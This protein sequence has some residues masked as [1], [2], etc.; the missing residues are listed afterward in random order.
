[1]PTSHSYHSYLI[2]SLGDPQEAAA[3]LDAVLED[4]TLEELRLAT[5]NVAEAR[6][7]ILDDVQDNS[8]ERQAIEQLI[9]GLNS[10]SDLSTLL[11]ILNE[12]GFKISVT[13]KEQVA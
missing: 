1:M 6:M 8:I 11:K 7:A 9:F 3:Y 2:Q 12:L 13:P 10:V 4:G 5:R